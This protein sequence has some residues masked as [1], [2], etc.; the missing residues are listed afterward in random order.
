[1]SPWPASVQKRLDH[2]RTVLEEI[3]A[4]FSP[5]IAASVC[6]REHGLRGPTGLSD[7]IVACSDLIAAD[8]TCHSL[9]HGVRGFHWSR[10][11]PEPYLLVTNA[12]QTLGEAKF[13]LFH[14]FGE[15]LYESLLLVDSRRIPPGPH[16]RETWSDTFACCALA[17][18]GPFLHSLKRLRHDLSAVAAT[19]GFTEN[20][21]LLRVAALGDDTGSCGDVG[22]PDAS[23]PVV[24]AANVVFM[25]GAS[26]G[27]SL[28]QHE[29]SRIVARINATIE[30]SPSG[31]PSR[32]EDQR[33][34]NPASTHPVAA[35]HDRTLYRARDIAQSERDLRLYECF[36]WWEIPF[37]DG[38]HFS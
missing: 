30:S 4:D 18:P 27:H 10:R 1:M 7:A 28:N 13:T 12:S 35:W 25:R 21:L 23:S 5:E 17:R 22:S 37:F 26:A 15:I 11:T 19:W 24:L 31:T 6:D 32:P 20:Q 38:D 33:I 2:Y 3:P 16:A 36:P 29:R 14:E 8:F 9:P 34:G